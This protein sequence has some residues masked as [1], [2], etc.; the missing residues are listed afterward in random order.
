MSYKSP[1]KPTNRFLFTSTKFFYAQIRNG[2]RMYFVQII[3]EFKFF[4]QFPRDSIYY[5]NILQ[6]IYYFRRTLWTH[7]NHFDDFPSM[8]C[9]DSLPSFPTSVCPPPPLLSRECK[10][11]PFSCY[12][13]FARGHRKIAASCTDTVGYLTE[14]GDHAVSEK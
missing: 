10:P 6:K 8:Y 4:Y 11:Q 7:S 12:I 2:N 5:F 14:S 9:L 3:K 1:L 13:A